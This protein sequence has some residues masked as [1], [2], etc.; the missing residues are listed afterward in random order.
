MKQFEYGCRSLLNKRIF[1]HKLWLR[2]TLNSEMIRRVIISQWFC[3]LPA[4][5]DNSFCKPDR[6][7][8]AQ[9]HIAQHLAELYITVTIITA[10]HFLCNLQMGQIR[11]SVTYTRLE[12]LAGNNHTS[13]SGPF[14]SYEENEVTLKPRHYAERL[15]VDCHGAY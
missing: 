9:G 2:W 7:K 12:G 6:Y 4:H 14:V 11:Y 1:F 15:S 5:L 10:R 3:D 13:L 8:V